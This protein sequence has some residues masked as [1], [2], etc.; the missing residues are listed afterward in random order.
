MR[1]VLGETGLRR[2]QV[3]LILA[4]DA[5][6]HRL[7]RDYRR[8]DRPT[9]VLAFS[10]TE[11]WPGKTQNFSSGKEPPALGDVFISLDRAREQAR[12]AGH[13]LQQEVL[14]LAFHGLL[15]LAGWDHRTPGAERAMR[16]KEKTLLK[17]F[18]AV[19]DHRH[20]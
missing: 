18:R 16:R 8:M 12:E 10:Y 1:K 15:H 2:G 5:L 17:H 6:L 19:G 11:D 20:A 4:G 14:L 7:N 9:D 3:S 13:L